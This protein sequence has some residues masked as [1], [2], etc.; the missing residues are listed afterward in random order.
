MVRRALNELPK[1]LP[2]TYGRILRNID[3]SRAATAAREILRWMVHSQ[4]Q[5]ATTELLEVTGFIVQEGP[6]FERKEI[7]GDLND[8]LRICSSLVS[9]T[10]SEDGTDTQPDDHGVRHAT[11]APE[12]VRLAHASVRDYLVSDS[13]CLTCYSLHDHESHDVL[14]SCCLVYLL[15]FEAEEWTGH[16]HDSSFPLAR[17]A[18]EF[19]TEHARISGG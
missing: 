9:V 10:T 5:L 11:F 13:P 17:Y 16:D 12:Y 7:L 14:A 6:R 19:W 8:V 15:R 1:D 4:R 2:E 18:A 3:K